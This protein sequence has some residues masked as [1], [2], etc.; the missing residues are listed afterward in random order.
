MPN[1]I[2][3]YVYYEPLAVGGPVTRQNR[4]PAS[5]STYVPVPGI[6]VPPTNDL[7]PGSQFHPDMPPASHTQGTTT[8]TF[9]FINVSGCGAGQTSTNLANLP[10]SDPDN[11]LLVGSQTINI[12]AVY[13]ASGISGPGGGGPGIYLDAFDETTGEFLDNFFV[14]GIAPDNGLTHNVNVYG[15]LGVVPATETVT[16][17]ANP[18]PTPAV[19]NSNANFDKWD[20]LE[21]AGSN[22]Q[23]SGQNLIVTGNT[24]SNLVAFAF[25]QQPESV[26]I[27]GGYESPDII[28]FTPFST[29]SIGTVV[30]VIGGDTKV[31]PG[32]SYGFAARIHNDSEFEVSTKV[33][34]WT[35]PEGVAT[36]GQYLDTQVATVPAGGSTIVY[37][38][39]PFVN[40]GGID[41][42][43]CAAVSLFTPGTACSFNANSLSSATDIPRPDINVAH[44]CSAWRNTDTLFVSPGAPWHII[45]GLG[46]VHHFDP[47]AEISIAVNVRHVAADFAKNDKV[48][49]VVRAN[50]A[51]YCKTPPYLIPSLH[52]ELPVTELKHE[53]IPVSKGRIEQHKEYGRHIVQ[54]ENPAET[55]FKISG[56]VPGNAKPGEIYLVQVNAHYPRNGKQPSR[57]VSFL[58]ALVVKGK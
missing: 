2:Y 5:S 40:A 48:L 42:H 44:S 39:V 51:I 49:E 14:T 41:S 50:R 29:T 54:F 47:V 57:I 38:S 46:R 25:Y 26:Y 36:I 56:T 3:N 28:L 58:E 12:L 8:Y 6:I 27:T 23:V 13:L 16:A 20:I 4:I 43:T 53:I 17:A 34:F 21:G 45:L 11:P 1:A 37:S 33:T 18:M 9:G 55:E 22:P 10:G 24:P 7:A 35:I 15:S 19:I 30:P 32:V 31:L 52:E